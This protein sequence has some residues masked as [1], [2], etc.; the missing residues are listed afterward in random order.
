MIIIDNFFYFNNTDTIS[1]IHKAF[2]KLSKIEKEVKFYDFEYGTGS[3]DNVIENAMKCKF[4]HLTR[5]EISIIKDLFKKEKS[6]REKTQKNIYEQRFYFFFALLDYIIR[7]DIK[8]D[9]IW[10][11]SFYQDQYQ[12]FF[13]GKFSN[14]LNSMETIGNEP[15]FNFDFYGTTTPCIKWD[16]GFNNVVLFISN[17][18]LEGDNKRKYNKIFRK[19]QEIKKNIIN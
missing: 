2:N 4:S 7:N 14:E 9:F 6:L 18:F 12:G 16:S 3:L 15:V 1:D 19:Y 5:K 8:H 17:N 13:K 11:N 10:L